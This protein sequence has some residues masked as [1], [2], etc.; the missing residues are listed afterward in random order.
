MTKTIDWEKIES[1]PILKELV[2]WLLVADD[3]DK[4]AF[5]D[6]LENMRAEKAEAKV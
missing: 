4:A 3:E 5:A 6:F 1:D 2:E